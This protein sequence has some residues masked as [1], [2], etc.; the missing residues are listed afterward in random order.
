MLSWENSWLISVWVWANVWCLNCL[1][2]HTHQLHFPRGDYGR[3]TK[4]KV[5]K[6]FG[7]WLNDGFEHFVLHWS[8]SS[9]TSRSRISLFSY[10][11]CFNSGVFTVWHSVGKK[12]T[13][14]IYRYI[15]F[16]PW[17]LAECSLWMCKVQLIIINERSSV[18]APLLDPFSVSALRVICS[19]AVATKP[20]NCVFVAGKYSALFTVNV[21]EVFAGICSFCTRAREW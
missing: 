20:L 1:M 3:H 17:T 2:C 5:P 10:I 9:A 19:F 18:S 21:A 16:V 8:L 4:I 11:L 15:I 7:Q 12:H 6:I 13:Q 14:T